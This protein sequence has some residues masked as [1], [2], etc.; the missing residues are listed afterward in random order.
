M[1]A[2]GMTDMSG[3]NTCLHL[4]SSS[5]KPPPSLPVGRSRR[6]ERRRSEQQSETSLC[7]LRNT[8]RLCRMSSLSMDET[9]QQTA[10]ERMTDPLAKGEEGRQQAG[11]DDVLLSGGEG[12]AVITERTLRGNPAEPRERGRERM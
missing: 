12:E 3:G 4:L 7:H 8:E 9:A 11:R 6:C 5:L 1:R 2:S 10:S